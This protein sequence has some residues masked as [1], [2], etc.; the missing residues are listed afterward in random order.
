MITPGATDRDDPVV[1][2]IASSLRI[3]SGTPIAGPHER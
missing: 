3:T 1:I 2:T